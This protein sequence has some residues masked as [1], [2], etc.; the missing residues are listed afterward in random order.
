MHGIDR[1]AVFQK[2]RKSDFDY[3]Y[4]SDSNYSWIPEI[5]FGTSIGG[6]QIT[7]MTLNRTNRT[8]SH[9]LVAFDSNQ[10]ICKV[11]TQDVPHRGVFS[12][13][14]DKKTLQEMGEFGSVKMTGLTTPW[15]RLLILVHYPNGA[16][17]AMHC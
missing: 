15:S 2:D 12:Q 4:T 6:D 16:I 10:K 5:P 17:S 9:K 1:Y 8:S 13:T 7:V 3:F 11:W 14:I